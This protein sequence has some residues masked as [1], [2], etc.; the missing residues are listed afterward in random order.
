[1]LPRKAKTNRRTAQKILA[2]G[3]NFY[4]MHMTLRT[5]KIL[6]KKS[7]LSFVVSKKVAARAHERNKLKRRGFSAISQYYK[8]IRPYTGTLFFIKKTATLASYVD[9]EN[10]IHNLLIKSGLISHK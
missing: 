6:N 9:I 4:G 3:R 5:I 7:T 10:D 8:N 1:M 2:A